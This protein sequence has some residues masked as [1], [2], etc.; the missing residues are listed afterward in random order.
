MT[1]WVI[2][3]IFVLFRVAY[4]VRLY[5]ITQIW[6]LNLLTLLALWC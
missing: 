2:T 5:S 1:F 6:I 3:I 4:Y